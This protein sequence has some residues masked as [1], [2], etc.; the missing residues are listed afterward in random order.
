MI[1][2]I[3]CKFYFSHIF[4]LPDFES[5]PVETLGSLFPGA[6]INMSLFHLSKSAYCNLQKRG[7]IAT[8]SEPS[9]RELFRCLP[10][11]AL[12]PCEDVELGFEE[13]ANA[14]RSKPD[15]DDLLD[16]DRLDDYLAYFERTYI[17]SVIHLTIGRDP[18]LSHGLNL[19]LD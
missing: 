13:V 15:D 7:L 14:L 11:L 17:R 18:D 4:Y 6:T 10:A 8:Y 12:L 19:D 1:L 5:G 9:V 2:K 3:K 16:A